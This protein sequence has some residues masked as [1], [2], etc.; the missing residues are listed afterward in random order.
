[1]NA[2]KTTIGKILRESETYYAIPNF[3]R[4]YSWQTS[5]ARDFLN[6]LEDSIA[7][8]KNHYF[9]TVVMVSDPSN[10]QS[11]SKYSIDIIDGQQR[12]TTSLLLVTAVYHLVKND[13]S[14]IEDPET[15]AD[16]I[17]NR[18]LFNS[19]IDKNKIKLRTV[20]TDDQVLQRIFDA[21][22]DESRLTS[23]EKLSNLYQVYSTFR[24]YLATRSGIDKYIDG[25]EHFEVVAITLDPDDDNPQRVFESINSTGKPLTD[26]DKIRNFAL[27]LNDSAVR[28][29]VYEKYWMRIEESLLDS[30]VITDFFRVYIISKRQ[31]LIR[32]NAVYPEFKKQ[33][34]Q[35]VGEEQRIEDIDDFYTD[36]INSLNIYLLLKIE[37]TERTDQ[38]QNIAETIFKMRYLKVDL[39]IPF[40]MSVLRYHASGHLQSDQIAQVFNLIETYFSRRIISGIV[41]TSVDRF[42]SSLH[43]DVLSYIGTSQDLD[44]VEVLKYIILNRIGQTRLPD[45]A[46]YEREIR[47]REAYRMSNSFLIYVLTATE[48][49]SKDRHKTTLHDVAS[50]HKLT[51]EHIM[52]QT[53]TGKAWQDMLGEDYPRIH[54]D[55][56]HTLANLTLTGYNSEYSNLPYNGNPGKDKMTLEAKDKLSGEMKK[57]GFMYSP[58]EINEWIAKHDTW[59]EKTLKDRQDWWVKNLSK[60]WPL[61]TTT[62]MPTAIDTSIDLLDEVDLKGR[63][64]KSVEV[65]GISTSV[66]TWAEALDVIAETLYDRYPNFLEVVNEDEY[67]SKYIRKDDSI[68]GASAEILNTGYYIDTGTNTNSKLR[69]LRAFGRAYNLSS[70][71][72]RAELNATQPD[73]LES[74]AFKYI[75]WINEFNLNYIHP[76]VSGSI[77]SYVRFTTDFMEKL[78]PARAE[79]NGGWKNG[80][81]YYYE[82]YSDKNSWARIQ[83]GFSLDDLNDIQKS[84][85]KKVMDSQNKYPGARNN[86]WF[87][88]H[89]WRLVNN[90]GEEAQKE[91]I[92]KVLEED[93]PQFERSIQ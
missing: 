56:L 46:E 50:G 85:H 55:Y 60:V 66:S 44:Y 32:E 71:D 61:P 49:R 26:G 82:L 67:L 80:R 21:N 76:D 70:G 20:N 30:D 84:G 77:N 38:Y 39:Y 6:D 88:I 87:V 90:E 86:H 34:E 54:N 17:R 23:R 19:T 40:A 73:G 37:D 52:P 92:R 25:L 2:P 64:V 28:D 15:T 69:L 68:F 81:A 58:L 62:F 11:K 35:Y 36:I 12:V 57:V 3:Q 78:I 13:P 51:I 31:A 18:Y 53:L 9:G 29:Y 79:K 4:P 45:D 91:S 5:N 48:S 8:N 83:L 47:T 89:S 16:A 24:N 65:F 75:G 27:M 42:L 93:I 59:N 10:K 72:L 41:T 43:R 74:R 63:S 14:L 22:G 33:F 7:R 1:M